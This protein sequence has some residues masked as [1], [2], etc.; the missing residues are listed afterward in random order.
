MKTVAPLAFFAANPSNQRRV[1]RLQEVVAKVEE[2]SDTDASSELLALEEQQGA[3]SEDGFASIESTLER[4]ENWLMMRMNEAQA[5]RVTM[6]KFVDV[7]AQSQKRALRSANSR[8]TSLADVSPR[9]V[10]FARVCSMSSTPEAP[11]KLAR[12]GPQFVSSAVSRAAT[13]PAP[14]SGAPI[15]AELVRKTYGE[16]AEG[17][18]AAA[19]RMNVEAL[20]A[21]VADKAWGHAH[22]RLH[23]LAGWA[24][25]LLPP[26]EMDASFRAL[27]MEM[28]VVFERDDDGAAL[29]E[30]ADRLSEAARA[31][32]C[33]RAAAQDAREQSS[34]PA[35][36]E[37]PST[38]P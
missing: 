32:R 30:F 35:S 14:R 11:A 34:A 19:A 23:S 9:V 8:H 13:V 10:A 36:E 18:L 6:E 12:Q 5:G 33:I 27:D 1:R 31:L 22:C 17:M 16:A 38:G 24:A 15:D 26:E 28:K 7:D 4:H 20:E 29:E 37:D 3:S 21:A 25:Y 2:Q